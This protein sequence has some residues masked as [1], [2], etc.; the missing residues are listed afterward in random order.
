MFKRNV[1]NKSGRKIGVIG[2]SLKITPRDVMC[3]I[4][5]HRNPF[6]LDR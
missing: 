3:Q 1:M 5:C 4:T 6:S 2:M